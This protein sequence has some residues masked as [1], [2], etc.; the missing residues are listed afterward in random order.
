MNPM[1]KIV[2]FILRIKDKPQDYPIPFGIVTFTPEA[3]DEGVTGDQNK[4]LIIY[5]YDFFGNLSTKVY[6]FSKSRIYAT[7][8]RGVPVFD[9]T[10]QE[11]RFPVFSKISPG[12]VVYTSRW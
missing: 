12:E 10:K 7:E 4:Q 9:K 11:I 3:L 2:K 6:P 8:K 5:D 1:S